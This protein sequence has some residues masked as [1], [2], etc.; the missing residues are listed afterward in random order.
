MIG[1]RTPAL[2]AAALAVLAALVLGTVLERPLQKKRPSQHPTHGPAVAGSASG[3]DLTAHRT[4]RRRSGARSREAARKQARRFL[5]AFLRYE[6][7]GADARI[8]SELTATASHGVVDSLLTETPRG[9]SPRARVAALRVYGPRAGKAKASALLA[10]RRRQP[11]LFE[12]VLRLRG[13]LWRVSELY[14]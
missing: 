5:N 10:Y 11:S 13:G 7:R 2:W 12:F 9:E 8:R 1:S 6:Q 14:P 3:V 4:R